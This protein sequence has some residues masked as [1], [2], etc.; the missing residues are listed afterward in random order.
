MNKAVFFH[1]HVFVK[2]NNG[3]Y[4]EGKL[5]DETW[6]RYTELFQELLVVCRYKEVF[7]E[8]EIEKL[9]LTSD[10][11]VKFDCI[12]PWGKR[13]VFFSKSIKN[14][15][16]DVINNSDVV[17]CRLP[18]FLGF[19]A[20]DIAKKNKKRIVCEV[21]GCPFDS[22]FYHGSILGKL[23]SPIMYLKMKKVIKISPLSIYVS[24]EF[25]QSRYP[26]NG[27]FCNASNVNIN[28]HDFRC[29]VRNEAVDILF[30]GSLNSLYKGLYDLIKAV[31][32][33]KES[34][35]VLNVHVL[36]SGSKG[37]YLNFISSHGL[38]DN[39]HFYSPLPGGEQVLD[40]LSKGDIYVQPSHTEGL[41]RSLIEAMSVGLPCIGTT[42]GGIPELLQDNCL[43][44]P[45][46]PE[47]LSKKL[48][49]FI[50]NPRLRH[51]ESKANLSK[52]REYES[53]VLSKRR[54]DFLKTSLF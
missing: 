10:E 14:K 22:Y 4:S 41:P 20:F 33:L 7:K 43:V 3:Y 53:D 38:E 9:N 52:S 36:G 12:K 34:G 49:E 5:T 45:K 28:K 15:L 23:A 39:I 13:E 1:D 19:I 25:L 17:I 29:T 24:N 11:K 32:I 8:S 42:V 27:D 35:V 21:V 40:W 31:S 30:I 50:E 47:K 54:H 18:S 46:Q 16:T 37:R 2:F 51:E 6:R 26:T 44:P 48:L